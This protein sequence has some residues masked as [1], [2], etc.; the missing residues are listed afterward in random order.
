M[1]DHQ[2]P[3]G[4]TGT[5]FDA[6][7]VGAGFAGM[8]MLHRL[9]EQGFSARVY[10][11][12]EGVGGTWYWNRYPGARCDVESLEYQY[13]FSDD[14]QKNWNWTERYAQQPEILQYCNHVAGKFDLRHDM[15]FDTRVTS[16]IYDEASDRW[17]IETDQGDRVSARFCIMAI[18]CLSAGR[19]PDFEGLESFQGDWYHTGAWPHEKVDFS[20]KRVGVIG[21]GSSAIQTI[22]VIA[23]EADLVTVFQRTPNFSVPAEQEPLTPEQIRDH[24]ENFAQIKQ[25][26]RETGFGILIDINEKSALEVSAEEREQEYESR[27]RTGGAGMLGAFSDILVDR[28][29]NDT[30][31]EFFHRK[32]HEAVEDPKVAD[33]LSPTDH[34]AG[35]KR[36]CVDTGYYQAFNRDNVKLIDISNDPIGAITPTGLRTSAGDEYEFD[37]IIYATGFDAMTGA[38]LWIDV[39]GREGTPLGEVWEAGPRSYLGLSMAGFPNLFTI[40]GPGSPSVLSNMIVSIEQ[41]VDWITQCM[42]DLRERSLDTIEATV[43]AQDAWVE[44]VNDS[45]DMTLWPQANSWYLGANIPGKPRVFMPYV[46]GV[47]VYAE[48]CAEVVANGYEGFVLGAVAPMSA[49][50]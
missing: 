30:T 42:V 7:I 32:I 24:K 16:A 41:H 47:N 34:P 36:L 25:A 37:S 21:T 12:G 1:P 17:A 50:S 8:Y 27:W 31:V 20:G 6:V 33:L 44:H 18:G 9:R 39:R 11:A 23:E 19:V 45:A 38:L 15:Q 46:G 3:Q 2:Q 5:E 10:E 4:E 26:A 22:P 14:L 28:E 35:T 48:K 29:A 13:S 43:E 40:T 49:T